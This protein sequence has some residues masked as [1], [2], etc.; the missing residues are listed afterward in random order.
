MRK[1]IAS[2][3]LIGVLGAAAGAASADSTQY[4]TFF[5]KFKYKGGE[6]F[7]GNIDSPKSGCVDGRKVVLYRKQNGNQKKLGG[8][9]TD[10][11][12]KFKISLSG[13]QIQNGKYYAIVKQDKIGNGAVCLEKQSGYVKV[14]ISG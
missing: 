2:A 13:G 6:S 3:L 8:D 12:G 10:E 7:S 9:K 4:P 5:T 11:N 1:A 14:T